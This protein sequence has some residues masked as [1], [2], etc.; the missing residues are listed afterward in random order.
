MAPRDEDQLRHMLATALAREDGPSALRYP[1][2]SGVGVAMDGPGAAAARSARPRP[3][4]RA[5]DVCMLAVGSMV[6]PALAAAAS[7][8]TERSNGQGN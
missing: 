3:C 8:R 7:R 6:H 2:G 4:A 5:T 1:R